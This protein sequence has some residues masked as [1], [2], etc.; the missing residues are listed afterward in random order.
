MKLVHVAK[1]KFLKG[2]LVSHSNIKTKRK[3]KLNFQQKRVWV[4]DQNKWVKTVMHCSELRSLR[5]ASCS[6]RVSELYCD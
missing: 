4:I 5:F 6:R 2:N 3:F 1:K